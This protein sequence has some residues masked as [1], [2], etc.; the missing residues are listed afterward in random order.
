[1]QNTEQRQKGETK[2]GNFNDNST[3]K[4]TRIN[5]KKSHKH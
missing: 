2:K 5:N 1:M 4:K 3:G